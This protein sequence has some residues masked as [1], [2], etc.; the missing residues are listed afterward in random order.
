[1]KKALLIILINFILFPVISFAGSMD[2]EEAAEQ[3]SDQNYYDTGSAGDAVYAR[4][5][6]NYMYASD[7]H[8]VDQIN[9]NS[10]TNHDAMNRHR[11]S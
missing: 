6:D 1:M 5:K 3:V 9:N 4:H 11:I 2:T 10:L 8:N 7:A